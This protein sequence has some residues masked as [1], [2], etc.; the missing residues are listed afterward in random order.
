[1]SFAPAQMASQYRE[2]SFCA[3]DFFGEVV[4]ETNKRVVVR[5][6]R[7]TDARAFRYNAQHMGYGCALKP[8][9]KSQAMYAQVVLNSPF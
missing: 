5:F 3:K 7:E 2:I 1:M 4:L 6:E 9:L 8:G